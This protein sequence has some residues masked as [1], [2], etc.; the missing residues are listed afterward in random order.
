MLEA[1]LVM[2]A[3][4]TKGRICMLRIGVLLTVL[5]VAAPQA[6]AEASRD[7]ES[8]DHAVAIPACTVLI[9]QTPQNATAYYNRGISYRETGQLDLAL[10]DYNRA[11]E[12]DPK[13]FEA[14]NNRGVL[15]M[16]RGDNKRALQEFDRAIKINPKYALAHNNSGEAFENM[17]Q[18]QEAMAAYNRAI[19][20]DPSYAPAFANRGDI[21]RKMGN[22]DN[23]IADYRQALSINPDN[24][25]AHAGLKLLGAPPPVPALPQIAK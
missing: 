10:A 24:G 5:A 3:P 4:R 6:R 23:A 21:W 7:C 22:R 18:F 14:Y 11:I 17:D 2:P 8:D 25:L 12:I 19:A 9:K 13:Y 15:Y 20:L 1:F 16:S